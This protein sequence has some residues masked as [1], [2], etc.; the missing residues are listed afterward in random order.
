MKILLKNL[1]LILMVLGALILIASF[2]TGSDLV[3]N[4]TVLG[5]S[6]ALMVI[7]LVAYIVLNKKIT[8]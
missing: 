1:G 3:N 6:L 4:N 2:V 5:G 8:D 7:G